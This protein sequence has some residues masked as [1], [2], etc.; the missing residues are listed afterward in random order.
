MNKK[1]FSKI[2]PL[3][4][5]LILLLVT[6]CSSDLDDKYVSDIDG[7]VYKL[8]WRIGDLYALLKQDVEQMKSTLKIV[9]DT[10]NKQLINKQ[11]DIE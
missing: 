3:A 8:D 5:C 6:G 2:I 11:G 4:I 9:E 10:A 1:I 7:N